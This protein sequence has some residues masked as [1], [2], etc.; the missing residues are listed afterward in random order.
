MKILSGK[1]ETSGDFFPTLANFNW[2]SLFLLTCVLYFLITYVSYHLFYT[3]SSRRITIK[4]KKY[5]KILEK[6]EN[7]ENSVTKYN[8]KY[9]IIFT[10]KNC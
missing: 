7:I 4:N 8:L 6:Q 3:K 9:T 1:N 10:F 2:Q 5:N